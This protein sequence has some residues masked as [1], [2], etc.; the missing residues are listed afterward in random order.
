PRTARPPAV[1]WRWPMRSP[2]PRE[3]WADSSPAYQRSRHP[4]RRAHTLRPRQ[5]RQPDRENAAPRR[6]GSTGYALR[7]R[8]L[9]DAHLRA[10]AW[11]PRD[12][13]LAP[14]DR[15]VGQ[16]DTLRWRRGAELGASTDRA[17]L[18]RDNGRKAA[19]SARGRP[20]RIPGPAGA[21]P[22]RGRDWRPLWA[23]A[24]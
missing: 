24:R 9:P 13:P 7:E 1:C 4:V 10:L 5:L 3:G 15:L 20:E 19:L 6:T 16:R 23:S 12:R 11:K 18:P 2:H 14:R 22:R 17:G 21:S 8:I